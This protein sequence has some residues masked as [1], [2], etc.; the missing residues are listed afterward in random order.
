MKIEIE[1]IGKISSATIVINGITVIGG[2]NGTGKSTIS[3]ILF[4]MFNGFH[5]YNK[6]IKNERLEALLI[7]LDDDIDVAKEI[8]KRFSNKS[9][10]IDQLRD[11]LLEEHKP[12]AFD[13]EQND[14]FEIKQQP[15][16]SLAEDIQKILDLP[17]ADILKR[18][19]RDTILQEF[20]DQPLNIYS[21]ENGKVRMSIKN[22]TIEVAIGANDVNISGAFELQ[23]NALYIDDPFIVD[24]LG[25]NRR[26]YPLQRRTHSAY[27]HGSSLIRSL[28]SDY[29][30][31]SVD[32]IL[33]DKKIE[34][35]LH[36]LD[37][38]CTGTIVSRSTGIRQRYTYSEKKN[39]K[40]LKLENLSSGLKT[41]VLFKLIIE[42]NLLE[43]NGV[44]ILDEPEIHL[45]PE[46]QI[47]LAELIV[48]IQKEFKMHILINTHSPY[49]LHALDV[50]SVKH[51]IKEDCKYYLSSLEDNVA[52]FEDVTSDLEKIYKL[53]FR[54]FQELENIRS[55]SL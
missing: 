15:K 12:I 42:K 30:P 55:E 49:F 27:N 7:D 13:D 54:P 52:V 31:N 36:K 14:L 37:S 46:W 40:H 47:V 22:N 18:I 21:E 9:Y 16:D 43:D 3:R 4:S 10:N 28:L 53:L 23:K 45:H 41:F 11:F 32:S 5:D 38:V 34:S 6:R 20:N 25:F 51:D 33:A 1:N 19:V 8:I 35:I 2:V 50:F 29:S 26:Y 17:D 24:N 39:D 44:M 48:L